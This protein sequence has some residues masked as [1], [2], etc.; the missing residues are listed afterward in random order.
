MTGINQDTPLPPV[1]TYQYLMQQQAF[2]QVID[3]IMGDMQEIIPPN[4]GY[5]GFYYMS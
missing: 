2:C 4:Y 3:K 5:S 1:L